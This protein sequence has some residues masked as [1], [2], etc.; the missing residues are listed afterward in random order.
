MPL[1]LPR[2][3]FRF[4]KNIVILL[5]ANPPMNKEAAD[6]RDRFRFLIPDCNID[7]RGKGTTDHILGD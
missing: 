4:L 3:H 1:P 6:I 2:F 5:V 7:E